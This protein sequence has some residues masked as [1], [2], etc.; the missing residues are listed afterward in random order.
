M[1]INEL[2]PT[3]IRGSTG[4]LFQLGA[5][6]S[7]M[8]S[9][10]LGLPD[11][12]GTENMWPLLLGLTGAF[13]LIQLVAL[14]F[15]PETPRYLL[16]K[17]DKVK[18]AENVLKEL[19]G[20]GHIKQEIDD[21]LNEANMEKNTEKFS[22]FQLFT[23]RSLLLPTIISIVLHLSQQLSGINAVSFAYSFN[24]NFFQFCLD[25]FSFKIIGVLLLKRYT[26]EIRH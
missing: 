1:Y 12:L 23:T 14:P 18:E 26:Q 25:F 7:I 6:F 20:T 2:S 17:Q 16:I 3:Q 10:I 21:M 11:I 15:C 24:F 13:S 22:I 9:Q 8:L 19:R 5:T 4:V